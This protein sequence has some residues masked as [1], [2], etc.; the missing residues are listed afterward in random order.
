MPIQ[1]P[2]NPEV[3]QE[4]TY[5]GKVWQWDGS[6]WVGVRQETGIQRSNIWSKQNLLIPNRK[7]GLN[8]GYNGVTDQRRTKAGTIP[9]MKHYM[10]R[11]LGQFVYGLW[12]PAQ[13]TTE[14]WFDAADA[15]TITLNGST[16]SQWDDKSGNSRNISQA[17]SG[18]QPAYSSV[19]SEIT[20][21]G[22]NDILSNSSVGALGLISVSMIA[23]IKMNSGG[24]N[25]DLPVGIGE[26]LQTGKIRSFYRAS[27]GTTVGFAGWSRD[28]AS[29]T[30]SWDV[31]GD[32]HI[33]FGSNDKLI[34]SSNVL[35]SRD[36][37]TPTVHSTSGD[38]IATADGFS[39]GS[40]RGGSVANYYSAISVKE[41]IVFYSTITDDDRQRIE[42]YLAHKW[43][44]TANLPAD[45]PY[46]TLPPLA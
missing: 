4:Y 15:S 18:N 6:A 37:I 2:T 13:I 42:G 31:G 35:L 8:S 21:D 41:I 7:F 40:L 46:K 9:A 29:S 22:N 20:F 14:L 1:F 11:D 39:V 36:G 33:F 23:V 28:V 32:Y 38:L 25:E 12:T 30:H 16:V 44:L 5:E 19:N 43:G 34:A 10:E 26:T 27:N 45:H 3:N 24:A 17:T